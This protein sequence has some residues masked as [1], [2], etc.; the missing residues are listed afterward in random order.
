[1]LE[2]DTLNTTLSRRLSLRNFHLDETKVR[3]YLRIK[4][5]LLKGSFIDC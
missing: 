4:R 5:V 3:V 1:M 2:L